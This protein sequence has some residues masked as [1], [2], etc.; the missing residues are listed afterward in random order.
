MSDLE[1]Q[2]I[3]PGKYDTDCK[4]NSDFTIRYQDIR[5]YKGYGSQSNFIS[6]SPRFKNSPPTQRIDS[7]KPEFSQEIIKDVKYL[8]YEGKSNF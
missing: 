2:D 6:T 5:K 8:K 4:S 1:P 7:F 3:G